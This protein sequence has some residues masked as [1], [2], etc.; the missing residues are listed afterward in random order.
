MKEF[1]LHITLMFG[2]YRLDINKP[3]TSHFLVG[4]NQLVGVAS[5]STQ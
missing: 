1:G 4:A 5:S 2:F 3:A